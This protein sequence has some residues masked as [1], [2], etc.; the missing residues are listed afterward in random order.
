MKKLILVDGNAILHRAYHSLPPFKTAKG[1]VTN[2]IY[3]F[4]RMLIEIYKKERPDYLGIAWD[5]K[6]PTFRHEQFKE[7]KATRPP[8]P[9]DLYPQL[10]RLKQVLETF[11][12]PMMEMDGFEADDLLGTAAH[13]AEKEKDLRTVIVTG[14]QDAFQLVHGNTLVMAPVKGISEVIFYDAKK[15]EEKFGVK[16]EQIIDY[17]AL[18]GDASD[19]IPGVAGIGPKQA[20]NFL[21]KYGTLDA[22]YEHLADLTPAQRKKLEDGKESAYMS[23]DIATIRLDAPIEFSLDKLRTHRIDYE[24]ANALF[25]ELEFR[26]LGKKLE[27]LRELLDPDFA[28]APDNVSAAPPVQKPQKS[29]A[30]VETAQQSL[31]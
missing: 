19:N 5:R 23:Q 29:S 28:P 24:K 10:P 8:P 6:A 27:E 21:Q 17:K 13:E 3:G 16:P 20:S 25:D 9:D 22:L 14:D 31:F 7:Y 15:V 26:S 4:L 1:E 2:A 18:C 30:P 12:I 11:H